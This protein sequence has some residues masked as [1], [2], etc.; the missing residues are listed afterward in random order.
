VSWGALS[1]LPTDRRRRIG[2]R[3]PTGIGIVLCAG[4]ALAAVAYHR[5]YTP[6][7][8]RDPRT[9]ELVHNSL[10]SHF[11]LPESTRIAGIRTVAGGYLAFRFVCVAQL[12][13]FTPEQLPP[14]SAVPRQ[15]DYTSELTGHDHWQHVSVRIEP[16][17]IWEKV[18]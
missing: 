15:V 7:G 12:N 16:L 10:T 11:L 6:P 14:G 13:G 4:L 5:T 1:G 17:L 2:W 18:K 3:W 8:C 9:L